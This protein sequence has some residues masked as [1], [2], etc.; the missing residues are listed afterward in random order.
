MA[1]RFQNNYD[2]TDVPIP[3]TRQPPPSGA[4]IRRAKTLT[5]PERGVATVPLINQ[6]G[7]AHV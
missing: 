6:I 7:R 4:T 1:L 2:F 3:T 5:K